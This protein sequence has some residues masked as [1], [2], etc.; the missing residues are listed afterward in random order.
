MTHVN[1]LLVREE[2][3]QQF[4]F[5]IGVWSL[6][7]RGLIKI[8]SISNSGPAREKLVYNCDTTTWCH[9][10]MR[11]EQNKIVGSKSIPTISLYFILTSLWYHISCVT[12]VYMYIFLWSSSAQFI[13]IQMCRTFGLLRHI[14]PSYLGRGLS[15]F[16]GSHSALGSDLLRKLNQRVIR[17]CE[18][19]EL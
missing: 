15:G 9:R 8:W 4:S 12:V 2:I 7:A 16:H 18:M 5:S 3:F 11:G 1:F 19:F 14:R 17:S 10:P 13:P 6:N